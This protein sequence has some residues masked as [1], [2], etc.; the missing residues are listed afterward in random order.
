MKV[1]GCHSM[2]YS[3]DHI[4]ELMHVPC[5][6]FVDTYTDDVKKMKLALL[7]Y[8][9]ALRTQESHPDLPF[10]IGNHQGQP[11]VVLDTTT[12]GYPILPIPLPSQT[13]TKRDWEDLFTMYMGSHYSKGF[14]KTH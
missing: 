4:A 12:N 13:W 14:K 8:M 5:A 2:P 11:R 9:K 7:T 10:G 1:A 6:T 3:F